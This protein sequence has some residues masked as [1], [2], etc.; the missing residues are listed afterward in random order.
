MLDPQQNNDKNSYVDDR[1]L[2]QHYA[3]L[4][5]KKVFSLLE[6]FYES[7]KDCMDIINQAWLKKDLKKISEQAHK[8]SGSSLVLGLPLLGNHAGKIETMIIN[9]LDISLEEDIIILNTYYKETIKILDEIK[10]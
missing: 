7:S 4:G 9:K 2:Q 3:I 8:L 5:E 10:I 6:K 1:I